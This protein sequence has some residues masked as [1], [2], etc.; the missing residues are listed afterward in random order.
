[1][2]TEEFQYISCYC[3]SW[4]SVLQEAVYIISIHLM[5]LFIVLESPEPPHADKFQYISCYCLSP[6]ATL[7]VNVIVISIH[8][9]LLFI[10]QL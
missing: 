3:L 5:L 8:L 4:W 2:T 7:L 9:M 1:M 10:G 6:I